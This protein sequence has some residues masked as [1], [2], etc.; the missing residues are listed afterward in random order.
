MPDRFGT[1]FA[2]SDVLTSTVI[3]QCLPRQCHA[4]FIRREIFLSVRDLISSI[5]KHL[6]AHYAGPK[7]YVWTAIAE[8]ILAKLQHVVDQN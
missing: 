8:S 7:P 3:V 1:L 6:K 4:E 2:A 5:M